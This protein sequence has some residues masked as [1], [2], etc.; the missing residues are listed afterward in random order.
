MCPLSN[1]SYVHW[2]AANL[3]FSSRPEADDCGSGSEWPRCP[4]ADTQLNRPARIFI[5]AG[6]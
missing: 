4:K 1:G 3:P 5:G 6:L 2:L